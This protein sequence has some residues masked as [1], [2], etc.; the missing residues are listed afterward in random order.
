MT[1]QGGWGGADPLPLG[2]GHELVLCPDGV[3]A[4]EAGSLPAELGPDR[5]ALLLLLR[6]G[7]RPGAPPPRL[8]YAASGPQFQ[9]LAG[10]GWE[11]GGEAVALLAAP[12]VP[13]PPA[14]VEVGWEEGG[15]VVA[16][17]AGWRPH[18]TARGSDPA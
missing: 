11:E 3:D 17:P 1:E 6:G 10:S 8:G 5:V 7:G 9:L 2:G 4:G 15:A 12:R 16:L 18:L 14:E 13:A